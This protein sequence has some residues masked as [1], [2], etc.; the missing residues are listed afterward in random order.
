MTQ[1]QLNDDTSQLG[2]GPVEVNIAESREDTGVDDDIDGPHRST[3]FD[4]VLQ[5][6][7][8]SDR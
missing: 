8:P 2:Q 1:V 6:P 5:E 3:G 4:I 7:T